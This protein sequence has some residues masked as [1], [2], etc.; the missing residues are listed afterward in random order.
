MAEGKKAATRNGNYQE[1]VT[2]PLSREHDN[3]ATADDEL[4]D[5]DPDLDDD[6]EFDG[7]LSAIEKVC[8]IH[9]T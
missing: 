2:L 8:T 5:V 9:S 3:D 1:N 6:A 7:V 4:M